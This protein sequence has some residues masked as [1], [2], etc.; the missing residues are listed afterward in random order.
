M[1]PPGTLLHTSP[2]LHHLPAPLPSIYPTAIKGT[3][4]VSKSVFSTERISTWIMDQLGICQVFCVFYY[5]RKS[6]LSKCKQKNGQF[7]QTTF[8]VVQLGWDNLHGTIRTSKCSSF[9]LTL[10][11]TLFFQVQEYLRKCLFLFFMHLCTFRFW[12]R[13]EDD[14][15][16]YHDRTLLWTEIEVSSLFSERVGYHKV[17]SL[18]HS[19]KRLG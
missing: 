18:I 12:L 13:S 17:A 9:K 6:D 5:L 7:N 16:K 14:E 3:I 11:R 10:T 1:I 2:V 4:P 19:Y 15:L 8:T